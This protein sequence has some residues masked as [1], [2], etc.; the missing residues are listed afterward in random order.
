M[1]EKF[2]KVVTPTF[3]VS[4]PK[5]FK[6]ELNEL[7]GKTE[8]SILMLIDKK[9]DMSAMKALAKEAVAAKWG[10]KAPAGIRNPFRDGDV[11]KAGKPEYAGQ[12]FITA[13]RQQKPGLVDQ[14]LQPIMEINDF[15]PG[16]YARATVTAYAYDIKGNKGVS[17]GLQNI[18]KVKDGEPLVGRSNAEDDFAP[19]ASASNAEP[20]DT[21]FG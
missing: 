20:V 13:K 1:A 12:Y 5:V 9:S 19:V 17:F 10:D 15:Y 18:Q 6:A 21:M 3:R 11:E 8:Y 7:S 14:D 4:F 16:C 2:K